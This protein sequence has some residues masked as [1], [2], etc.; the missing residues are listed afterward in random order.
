[1]S[2]IALQLYTVRDACAADLEGTLARTAELGFDGVELY[3]LHGHT[4]EVVRELLDRNGI[5]ACGRHALLPVVE[6]ELDRLAEE[7]RVLGTDRLVVSWI[8]P[9]RS[10]ADAESVH[11]RLLAAAERA[12]GLGLRLGFHNH[13]GEL[14]TLED[15]RSLLD[16]LL[17][18]TG[19]LF[20][21]LDLGWV[22]YAGTDPLE[23]LGRMDGRS[24]LVHV[25][26]MRRNGSRFQPLGRGDVDYG[27]L[28][29]VAE[30]AGVEWLIV[31]QDETSGEPFDDVAISIGA[32]R[33]LLGSPR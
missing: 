22:W 23:L 2:R 12:A 1:V 28:G 11:E 27:A 24:P 5:V 8:E 20:L 16:R 30:G 32:L 21:E 19:R 13:D 29:T 7:L 17:A 31:E 10:P 9:P 3:D 4:P 33:D 15:G 6:E 26:D 14:A 18:S 25:K